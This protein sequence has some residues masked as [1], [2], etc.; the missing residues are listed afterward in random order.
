[1]ILSLEFYHGYTSAL[2]VLPACQVNLPQI[3]HDIELILSDD[4]ACNWAEYPV[5]HSE[6]YAQFHRSD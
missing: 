1:M 6:K 5:A 4:L 2:H 3:E